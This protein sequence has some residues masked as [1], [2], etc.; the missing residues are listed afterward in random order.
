MEFLAQRGHLFLAVKGRLLAFAMLDAV[1]VNVKNNLA[2]IF[3][4]NAEP[5]T[6]FKQNKNFPPYLCTGSA[7]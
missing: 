7:R 5:H 6:N 4:W 2:S 3:L 1:Y